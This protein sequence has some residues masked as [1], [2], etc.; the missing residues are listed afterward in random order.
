MAFLFLFF[1]GSLASLFLVAVVKKRLGHRMT[2]IPGE[3]SSHD[4]P[5][6]RGGGLGIVATA[7]GGILLYGA[8]AS[9]RMD[10]GWIAFC[11]SA[12]LISGISLLDD[13]RS[14]SNRIR[15]LA[16]S[17]AAGLTIAC[18][19]Y[20]DSIH[21]PLLG[22]IDIGLFGAPLTFVWI[23]GLINAYNF[24]DGID[25]LA[26]SQAVTA[27]AGWALVGW[28]T[29]QTPVAVLGLLLAA[30]SLGF[31]WHNWPPATIFMGDVGS[32][33]LGYAFAALPL[34]FAAGPAGRPDSGNLPLAAFLFV[35]PM[36][37]DASFTI[38]CRL[39]RGENVFSAHRSHLYQRMAAAGSHRNATL[40][41][42]G[43]SLIGAVL[44]VAFVLATPG[45]ETAAALGMPLL[46]I[47]LWLIVASIERRQG[48][49][50]PR[51]RTQCPPDAPMGRRG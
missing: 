23:V 44:G 15:F 46:C 8:L 12:L 29:G 41:Y 5:T 31:L 32:C 3:R 45:G 48:Q 7:L 2:D 27:G 39:R 28:M 30:G 9:W 11:L 22:R 10:P 24:M 4:R 1:S 13:F 18:L 6:P 25:G 40:L 16:H 35:W 49:V 14:L 33:F 51:L 17:V 42:A 19:G 26:G 38:V 37:F 36:V 50:K 47:G 43:L 21:F 34:F 20:F